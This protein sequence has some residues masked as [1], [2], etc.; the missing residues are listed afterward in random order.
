MAGVTDTNV[1]RWLE[2]ENAVI[3][4]LLLDDRLASPILAAVDLADISDTGNRRIYQAARALLLEGKPVDPVTIRGKVGAEYEQRILQLMEITPTTANW[5][6]YA[7]ILHEQASVARIRDI[8][9]E[10]MAEP[11]LE[12]CRSKI[13]ALS[14]IVATGKGVEAWNMADAYRHFMEA[15]EETARR[16]YVSYGFR[17]LDEGTYTEPGDV[18]VL[19][20]EPSSGKTLLALQMAYHMAKTRSVGFFSLETNPAKLTDRLVSSAVDV[21]FNDIKRQQ[22][23]ESDWQ[24]VAEGGQDFTSRRLV[25]IRGSGMT[26]SQIQAVSRSYGFEVIFVDYVQLIA[27]ETDPRLGQTHAMAAI[28]RSMHM[29][30]QSS[31]TLVVELSQLSRPQKQGGWK[32]PTM[33]DLKETGQ[34][35]QDADLIMLLFKPKKGEKVD[36]VEIDVERSRILKVAKQKEGRLGRWPMYFDGSRQRMSVMDMP[37]GQAVMRKYAAAAKARKSKDTAKRG[38]PIPNQ[39]SFREMQ[40]DGSMPF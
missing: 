27:P 22:L 40:D 23:R 38:D 35:E 2:A 36:D 39:V 31:G 5:R 11:T 15:Q 14:E 26:A 20:G 32:E 30:A 19:A 24:R 13:A 4:A 37:D 12:G 10:I 3:G 6:E 33:H 16:E 7:A 18:V 9:H 1:S 8:A 29:F 25:L 17:V 21:D 34:L 28:S